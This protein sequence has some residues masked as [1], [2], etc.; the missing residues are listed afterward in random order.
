M[1]LAILVAGWL[2]SP[3]ISNLL[4]IITELQPGTR[5]LELD[6]ARIDHTTPVEQTLNFFLVGETFMQLFATGFGFLSSIW[7][8]VVLLRLE[9]VDFWFVTVIILVQS[10]RILG[11]NRR[12]PEARFFSEVPQVYKDSHF[13]PMKQT[14]HSKSGNDPTIIDVTKKFMNL[15]SILAWV[16]FVVAVAPIAATLICITLPIIRLVALAGNAYEGSSKDASKVNLKSAL[17]FFYAL[18]LTQG[19]F[20]V[21]YLIIWLRRQEAAR[22]MRVKCG[23]VKNKW[24]LGKNE[25]KKL[26]NGYIEN[27]LDSCIE[28]GVSETFK[29]NLVSFAQ[30]LLR[31]DSN[32]DH[33]TAV[34]ILYILMEQ[35]AHRDRAISQMQSSKQCIVRLFDILSPKSLADKKIK[36]YTAA[37]VTKLASNMQLADISGAIQSIS[38]TLDLSQQRTN[39]N[40]RIPN[41]PSESQITWGMRIVGQLACN[42]D[43]C[44][45]MYNNEGLLSK[46]IA[47]LCKRSSFYLAIN[48]VPAPTEIIKE[49]L[50]VVTKVIRGN[51]EIRT[52]LNGR[53][54]DGAQ[55][56]TKMLTDIDDSKLKT[57]L[58]TIVSTLAEE[59]ARRGNLQHTADFI[60]DLLSLCFGNTASDKVPIIQE[61]VSLFDSKKV[62][63][64]EHT[65]EKVMDAGHTLNALARKSWENCRMIMGAQTTLLDQLAGTLENDN[66][67]RK[68]RTLAAQILSSF[69]AN[70]TEDERHILGSLRSKFTVVLQAIPNGLPEAVEVQVDHDENRNLYRR[71]RQ[72]ENL[73]NQVD[74]DERKLTAAILSLAIHMIAVN[75]IPEREHLMPI[76]DDSFVEKLKEIVKRNSELIPDCVD[77]SSAMAKLCIGIMKKYPSTVCAFHGKG[78][79]EALKT[80]AE[81]LSELERCMIMTGSIAVTAEYKTLPSIVEEVQQRQDNRLNVYW[82]ENLEVV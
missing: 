9:K 54:F 13:K 73:E 70:S 12:Y 10:V 42:P 71:R 80:A 1:V 37:V 15:M 76:I 23:F 11:F 18:V 47:P 81:T 61:M 25:A 56:I 2:V 19:A 62:I 34:L 74:P 64:A 79:D 43:N 66:N 82:Y 65:L 20:L 69:C 51:D 48:G 67:K 41:E 28:A 38:C 5:R 8:T 53:I 45:E 16:A 55:S 22:S 6:R 44:S 72:H 35:P 30:D 46:I 17:I 52:R 57:L 26:V 14:D 58:N 21:L 33:S 31:N 32:D 3:V 60:H 36:E 4:S 40:T 68:H 39:D 24:G 59:E 77:I 50:R 49:S 29:R 78:I 27:T 7:A 75:L 63:N